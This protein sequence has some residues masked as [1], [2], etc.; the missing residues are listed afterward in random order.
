[1]RSHDAAHCTFWAWDEE[2]SL[3]IA[4][5][6]RTLFAQFCVQ[7]LPPFTLPQAGQ[8]LVRETDHIQPIDPEEHQRLP[9]CR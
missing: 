5:Q 8:S 4:E 6:V 2:D 1:M 7:G 3:Y 9:A